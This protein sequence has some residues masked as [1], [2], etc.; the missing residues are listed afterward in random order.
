MSAAAF[1][2][3]ARLGAF[4]YEDP[5][6]ACRTGY[7]VRDGCPPGI[8]LLPQPEEEAGSVWTGD[9]GTVRG[10]GRDR[11]VSPAVWT[12]NGL[13]ASSLQ[14][15]Q[16][17]E[18]A[19]VEPHDGLSVYQDHRN[20]ASTGQAYQLIRGFR[21]IQQVDISKR[22]PFRR[23]K[24]FRRLTRTSRRGRVNN[25][26][27]VA[28]G[29]SSF[30]VINLLPPGPAPPGLGRC[31]RDPCRNTAPQDDRG[32]FSWPAASGSSLRCP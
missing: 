17:L 26:L 1:D 16:L 29:A 15:Q 27:S 30:Q 21:M 10:A 22:D 31:W 18:L 2:P 28:H 8:V 3:V 7:P 5:R 24:L 20:G 14:S 6:L 23:K 11:K 19:A 12:A 13:H 4:R 32:P 9:Y 25:D